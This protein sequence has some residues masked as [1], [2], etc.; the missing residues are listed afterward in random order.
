MYKKIITLICLS[1]SIFAQAISLDPISVENTKLEN[2]TYIISEEESLENRS[3]S[4]Q[5]KLENDV[6]FSA[7]QNNKNEKSISFRGLDFKAT[8]YVEDG[9]AL[10]RAS[11]GLVDTNFYMGNSQITL[12]DGSGISSTGVSA[13]GGQVQITSSIPTKDFETKLGTNISS[14]DEFY[15][16][17][18]GTA[19]DNIYVQ[20][21]ASYYHRSDFELSNDYNPTL[22]ESKG[23]RTNSDKEQTNVSLKAGMFVTDRLHLA[24][25]T[26][27]ST[28]EYGITPNTNTFAATPPVWYAYSRM[29]T[30]ELSS[31]YLYADY[32]MN[33]YEFSFRAYYDDYEDEYLIYDTIKY[34]SHGDTVTYNDYRLGET[35]SLTRSVDNHKTTFIS[36]IDRNEHERVGG[37]LSSAKN[38]V[39][40]YKNSLLHRWNLNN[41]FKIEGGISYTQMKEKEAADAGALNPADDKNAF[42]AQAKITYD[43]NK[44]ILY[45]SIAKKSRMPSMSEMFTFFPWDTPNPGL[46]PEKSMQYTT[47]YKYLI[48]EKSNIDLS[49]YYYAIDDLIIYRSNTFINRNDAKNYGT[50]LRF[51]TKYFKHNYI[52]LSYAYARAE[53]SKGEDLELIAKN[54]VILEDTIELSKNINLYLNYTYLGSR[55]S[56][57]SATYTDEQKKLDDYNILD[58]QLSYAVSDSINCRAGIKNLLDEDYEWEYG[59][60]A[61]G[62]SFYLSLEWKI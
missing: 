24:A 7:I 20:A 33:N 37:G 17:Y 5:D 36:R 42:D 52:R 43:D 51:N 10:Y 44:N 61:E 6:S 34:K 58:T 21:D 16:G 18:V 57:N 30:K 54:K 29:D 35:L 27:F 48:Q 19:I 49:L 3:I 28:S 4:L 22:T 60:P 32:D 47:G 41:H 53:D 15:Y 40:T 26:S 59:F 39:D 55:S 45:G 25:K 38:I 12:N 14:N 23:Q 62:R 2:E 31:F 9:I 11:D 46:K 1:T 50:E 8:D 13:M 56:S